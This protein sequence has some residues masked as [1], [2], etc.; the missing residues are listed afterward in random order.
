MQ[1]RKLYCAEAKLQVDTYKTLIKMPELQHTPYR[2]PLSLL[3]RGN[4]GVYGH[5]QHT[6]KMG[7]DLFCAIL[8]NSAH[9]PEIANTLC[10]GYGELCYVFVCDASCA[11][12]DG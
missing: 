12:D 6:H 3:E 2:G 1:Q 7:G 4:K 9:V 10:L 8:G 5:T 11:A